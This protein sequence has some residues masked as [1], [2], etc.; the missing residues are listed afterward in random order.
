MA[1]T[2]RDDLPDEQSEKYF[3]RGLDR[4]FTDL[5]VGQNHW[6]IAPCL[7]SGNWSGRDTLP[8]INHIEQC[9]LFEG[10]LMS[11]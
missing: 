3:A 4:Q 2:C 11:L 6:R 10:K 1:R 7:Q 5:P 8:S 9:L